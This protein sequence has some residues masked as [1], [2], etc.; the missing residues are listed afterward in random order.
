MTSLKLNGPFHAHAVARVVP[1]GPLRFVKAGGS[2]FGSAVGIY[3]KGA[4]SGGIARAVG[5]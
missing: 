4:K 2:V 3:P 1:Q 5:N